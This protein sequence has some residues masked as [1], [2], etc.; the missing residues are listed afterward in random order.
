MNNLGLLCYAQGK[1][2]EAEPLYKRSLTI[3]EK[4]LGPNHPNVAN[5]CANMAKC[6][7]KLGREHEA[8]KLEARARKIPLGR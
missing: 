2:G 6:Y 3:A 5:I 7:K 1:Y 8:E 4:T